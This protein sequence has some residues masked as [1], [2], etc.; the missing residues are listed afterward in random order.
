MTRRWVFTT[1]L[2]LPAALSA[3]RA[4][5]DGVAV[6]KKLAAATVTVRA[7]APE[8]EPGKPADVT[9]FSGV[10]LGEGLIVTFS[11]APET[12]RYRLTLPHGTQADGG[13]RVKDLYSGLSVLE[14]PQ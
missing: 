8:S 7:S 1:W 13:L 9:V 5:D 4:D 2:L 14:I 12:W 6:A 10:S 3:A 11:S